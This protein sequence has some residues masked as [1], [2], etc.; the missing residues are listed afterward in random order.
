MEATAEC[1]PTISSAVC[2]FPQESLVVRKKRD[3]M[4]IA[5]LTHRKEN[6]KCKCT[7]SLESP[8]RTIISKKRQE[9]I[10]DQ[11]YKI[12]NSVENRQS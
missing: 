11:I 9:Y 4:K 12:R 6:N 8:D 1:I 5:S 3:N 10:Q 2:R 7:L